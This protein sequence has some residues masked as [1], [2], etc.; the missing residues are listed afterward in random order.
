MIFSEKHASAKIYIE[1]WFD[2]KAALLTFQ[3]REVIQPGS[4]VF[5]RVD[6]HF[7]HFRSREFGWRNF[8][9]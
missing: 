9:G 4:S 6:K 2:T 3:F 5:H 1:T 7:G 8:P